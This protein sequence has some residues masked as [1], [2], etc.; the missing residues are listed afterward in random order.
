MK[1]KQALAHLQ[2]HT[3]TIAY[4][5]KLARTDTHTHILIHKPTQSVAH[6]HTHA[7]TH[8][9]SVTCMMRQMVDSGCCVVAR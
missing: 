8:T 1:N 7:R 2:L 4:T 6:V 5:P 9:L 3:N